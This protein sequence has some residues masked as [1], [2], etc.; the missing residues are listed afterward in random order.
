MSYLILVE[1]L[2]S[3]Q[4][5]QILKVAFFSLKQSYRYETKAGTVW[6]KVHKPKQ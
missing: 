3:G 5:R 4:Q 2:I 1:I 6:N